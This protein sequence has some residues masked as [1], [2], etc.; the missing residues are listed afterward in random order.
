MNY[1]DQTKEELR[2]EVDKRG[3]DVP[4]DALKGDLIAALEADDATSAPTEAVP[5][6]EPPTE[7]PELTEEESDEQAQQRARLAGVVEQEPGGRA[8]VYV[9][10][11]PPDE[12]AA[13]SLTYDDDQYTVDQLVQSAPELVGAPSYMV[14][15]ALSRFG[16]GERVYTLEQTRDAVDQLNQHEVEA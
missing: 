4:A 12:Q 5:P 2:A 9:A 10:P 1:E 3:L 8:G 13:E 6:P 14:R 11:A 16:G 7:P 15:A